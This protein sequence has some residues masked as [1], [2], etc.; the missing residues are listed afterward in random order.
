MPLIINNAGEHHYVATWTDGS[1]VILKS[2][3]IPVTEE[4]LVRL[5]S[6]AGCNLID[7]YDALEE[8]DPRLPAKTL[9]SMKAQL[10]ELVE[11]EMYDPTADKSENV[12]K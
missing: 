7:V 9:I 4:E 11:R 6:E 3:E 10:N 2:I 1:G 8:I 12:K 5:L